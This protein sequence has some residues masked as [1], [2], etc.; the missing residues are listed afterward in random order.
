MPNKK[1]ISESEFDI[2]WYSGSGAGGQHRNKHQNCCRVVHRATGISAVGTHSRSREANRIAALD[3]CMER[4]LAAN[5]QDTPRYQAGH[6]RVRTYHEP[7]NRVVD[8]A[9]GLVQT[10][11][12]VVEKGNISNMIDARR[13]AKGAQDE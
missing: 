3:V 8:H 11:Q 9:S 13:L 7:D 10:Y 4:V 5:Q 6:E 1:T 2:Q 12:E